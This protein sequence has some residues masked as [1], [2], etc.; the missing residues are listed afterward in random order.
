MP[1]SAGK[2]LV[3][4]HLTD[5]PMFGGPERQM[6]GLGRSLGGRCRSLFWLFPD[7][8]SYKPF[9]EQLRRN[10]LEVTVLKANWPRLRTTIRELIRQIRAERVEV[11]CTQGYKGD[12]LGLIAA[13]LAGVPI[14]AVSRGWTSQ[15]RRV[16]LYEAVDRLCLRWMDRVV[17]V[18]EGQAEK[19]RRAGVPPENVVVIRNAIQT[20]RFAAG[21]VEVRQ[22]LEGLFP[23]PPQRIVGAV[24]RLSPEK[25]FDVL[26]EAAAV[27][28]RDNP[29]VGFVQFGDGR[30]RE[31][32]SQR[33]VE[34]GLDARFILAGF[35]DDLDRIYPNLDLVVLPSH[36]EG[37]PNVAL[38]AGAAGVP[39]V[40]TAVG[41]TPEVVQDGVNGYLVPPGQP[42]VLARR[43]LDALHDEPSRRAMGQSGLDRVR[44]EFTLQSQAEQYLKLF[45]ALRSAGRDLEPTSHTT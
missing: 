4:A 16:R 21:D 11:L 15:T 5:S 2:D 20:E 14:V 39:V 26:L 44:A 12:L 6:I 36:T 40:A 9:L 8:E 23:G 25:G 35:R 19:V 18:S 34:L 30:L 27:V 17:C 22:E 31:S 37:L 32:M 28:G 45:E 24:G 13:R 33:I 42:D 29:D 43:I 7:G 38:E 10:E 41:G 3:V 1:A